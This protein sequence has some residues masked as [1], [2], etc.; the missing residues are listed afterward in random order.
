M[1]CV[2]IAYYFCGFR[3]TITIYYVA[4]HTILF[5]ELIEEL[6]LKYVFCFRWR[7]HAAAEEEE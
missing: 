6:I 3:F 7:V 2:F 1:L 5:T 4:V